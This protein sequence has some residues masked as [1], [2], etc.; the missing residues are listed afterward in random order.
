MGVIDF[1]CDTV[2]RI[3]DDEKLG[4]YKNDF[5]VDIEKLRAGGYIAQFFA[6]YVNLKGGCDPLERC[7]TMIDRFYRELERN[8]AYI[9]YAGNSDDMAENRKQGKL[10]AFLTIEEGGTIKGRME[11]LRN[12]YRLGVR[13]ITLMWNYPN[14]IGYPNSD[15]KYADLGL[16]PFGI[17]AVREM[18]RLGI[19]IDVSHMSDGGFWDVARYSKMPFIASH[20]NA[21]A[22][23]GHS[24][25]L[26][27][28]MIKA[29]AERGG[30]IGI[31][32]EGSFLGESGVSRVEDMTRHI[33]H[34]KN[35]GGI[36]V[37]AIGTDFDGIGQKLE[38]KNASEMYKLADGLQKSGFT[39]DEIEKIMYRNAASFIGDVM[40]LHRSRH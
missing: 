11:N 13:L 14:E 23:R 28:E 4:L 8:S 33:A 5:N 7:L 21:R 22:I 16:T 20:S 29:L 2:L 36:D 27:D 12:F 24:R 15:L 17:D 3:V 26:T 18:N 31:N 30:V 39:E 32:F 38:I 37:I 6:M 40:G 19:A 9:R 35:V 25:N 34:I 10:S 1:H